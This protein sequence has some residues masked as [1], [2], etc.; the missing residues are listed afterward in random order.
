MKSANVIAA[1]A[2]GA[3]PAFAQDELVIETS[4]L[5]QPFNLNRRLWI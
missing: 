3:I 5:P 2:I 1:R 4:L